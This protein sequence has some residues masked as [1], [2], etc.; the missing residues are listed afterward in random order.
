MKILRLYIIPAIVILA[1]V[2]TACGTSNKTK[3]PGTQQQ[4]PFE[5]VTPSPSN[6]TPQEESQNNGQGQEDEPDQ[7]A[8]NKEMLGIEEITQLL[9]ARPDYQWSYNGFA[10]YGHRMVLQDISKQ[11]DVIIYHVKGEVDDMSGGESNQDLSFSVTYTVKPGVLIQN[12]TGRAMMDTSFKDLELIRTPL[13]KGNSWIQET[14]KEDG[15]PVTLK[16]TI[17]DVKEENGQKIY[18]VV[19]KDTQSEYYEKREIKEGVGVLSYEKLYMDPNGNFTIGYYIY[20]PGTG[21]RNKLEIDAYLPKLNTQLRYFGLAEYGHVGVLKKI[22]S[23]S[24]NAIYEFQGKYQDGSGINDKF[25]V[26]YYIDYVKGTVTEK[27]MSSTRFDPPEVNSKLHNLVI[28]KTP[29]KQGATWSHSTRVNGKEYKVTAK[30]KEYDPAT[31]RMKVTYTVKG[32]PGY[33]QNTYIEER[34]F[35]RGRGM[36]GFSNLMPGDIPIS[37][38]DA[39]DSKKL[40]EALINHMFGYSLNPEF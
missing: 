39:K 18:T 28:L 16:T 20:Y 14:T 22:S 25:T 19:Y 8:G 34:I 12:K 24:D 26:R 2:L 35:E 31:G 1:I 11:D 5:G 27:V 32:V 7:T 6:E 29:F 37:E 17:T 36:V 21:Y 30:I 13:Q 23:T 38:A 15:T 10:E 33:F 4:N 3:P 40:G 9:P